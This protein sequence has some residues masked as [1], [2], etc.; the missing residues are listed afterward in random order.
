M[1]SLDEVLSKVLEQDSSGWDEAQAALVAVV[2]LRARPNL[3]VEWDWEA[4]E[5]WIR[6]FDGS[7][8]VLFVSTKVPLVC[9]AAGFSTLVA[10]FLAH[11]EVLEAVSLEAAEFRCSEGSLNAVFPEA[12]RMLGLDVTGFSLMDLWYATV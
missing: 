11:V 7:G 3:T 8:L 5:G 9:A 4:G 2:T 6:L 10:S 1:I 12:S